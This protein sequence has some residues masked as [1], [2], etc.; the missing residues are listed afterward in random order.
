[1]TPGSPD[2]DVTS[3]LLA[4]VERTSD[5]VGVV[6]AESRVVYLNEAARKRLGVGDSTGLTTADV[7]PPHAFAQYYDEVRPALLRHG[8]W[9]GELAVLTGS[10]DAVPDVDDG[11]GARRSG[12]RGDH[13]RDPRPRDR[14]AVRARPGVGPGLRRPH[15]PARTG[16]SRRTVC[17]S[18]SAHSARDG[19]GVAV[20]LADVDGMKDIN[21]SFGHAAGDDALRR[22]A[23]TLSQGVRTS[24]T[25]AR[26]GG[27][28]F[29]VLLDGL[30]ETDTA[31]QVAERLR[32]AVCRAPVE[33]GGDQL[34]VTASFGL[35]VATAEDAPEELLQRADT[36]MYHAK[37]AGR[38]QGVRVRRRDRREH[39]DAR[40]RARTRSEPR[41]DPAARA[42]GRRPPDGSARRIP[43]AR[44]VGASPARASRRRAVRALGGGHADPAR[45]RPRRP[46]TNGRG[47]G[48]ERP[49]HARVRAPVPPIAR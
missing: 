19:R 42:V 10:G 22:L 3:E 29:V 36:A 34:V 39:H 48:P 37:A 2:A 47:R 27:D 44:A 35:A 31:W 15:E 40:R 38:R 16:D 26:L 30:E 13:P 21:D 5:L 25:V 9:R 49:T 45:H 33:L 24:D 4:F 6:D 41:A 23:R 8:T 11:R 1:M 18:R 20:I 46:P 28:E 43:G 7:F 12:R 17:A 14:D 32:D